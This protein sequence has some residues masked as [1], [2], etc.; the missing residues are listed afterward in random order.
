[1]YKTNNTATSRRSF[2]K[3][4]AAGALSTLCVPSRI[5]A[6]YESSADSESNDVVLRCAVMSDVHFNGSVESKEYERFVR[7]LEFMYKYSSQQSYSKFDALVVVGDMSNHGIEAEL[8]LFKKAMDA[9]IK[10]GT[11]TFLCMGNHEF[12]GGSQQLWRE[13]FGVE[14]NARYEANGYRFIAVS[15]EHARS[16]DGGYLYALDW[17][18][19]ELDDATAADPDKP[20]FVFQHY[21]VTPTVYGGRGQDD[22]GSEDMFDTL[23]S[24]PKVIDFSGHTH[25]PINDP[26]CAWQGCFTAFGTGTLSYLCRGAEGNRFPLYLPE[27]GGCAQFYVLEVRRDNSVVLKPYDLSTNSFFDVVYFVAEPGAVD[28]YVYTDARYS[29]SERPTWPEGSKATCSNV[30]EYGAT[31][32]TTQAYCKDVVLG[33]RLDLERFNSK[34]N[35]WEDAGEN[36]FWSYYFLRDMPKTARVEISDLEPNAKYR[37]KLFALNP[38]FRESATALEIEFQTLEEQAETIDKDAP[39]P[40]ANFL[41]I[42]V[43]DGVLVNAPVNGANEQKKLE[44][45]GAPK[46][47]DDS[48]LGGKKVVQFDG[49]KDCYK[50][51]LETADCARLKRSTI[52]AKFRLDEDCANSCSVFGGTQGAGVEFWIN[53]ESRTLEFWA[54]INGTYRILST[55][56]E[57]GRYYDAFGTYDGKALV[58][59]LDGKEVAR[60]DGKGGLTYPKNKGCQAFFLGAD[61]AADGSGEYLFKGRIERGRVFSWALAA[62]QVANLTNQN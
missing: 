12:Y 60:E 13:I 19:D 31:V 5:F 20:V 57:P 61:V 56:I 38:F 41:D 50:I 43:V 40:D 54:S 28:K 37:G 42:R 36:Y 14:P 6:K 21:P 8:S 45:F 62:E 58:L 33:Y 52:A 22:W 16:T 2:L 27:D 34:A 10:E 35:A 24:Y 18:R 59:Y 51:R 49:A 26:R 15:P 3:M 48:A 44:K 30:Y 23:Q 32:E 17:L 9:G 46:I 11:K 47:V 7:S 39:C 29:R 1:M 55:P 25:C 53:W 4:G